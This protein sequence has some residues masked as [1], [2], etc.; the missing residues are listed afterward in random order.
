MTSSPMQKT[1]PSGSLP[2]RLTEPSSGPSPLSLLAVD[3]DKLRLAAKKEEENLHQFALSCLNPFL[4]SPMSFSE[5]KAFERQHDCQHFGY[6]SG[7][8]WYLPNS[9]VPEQIKRVADALNPEPAD[10]EFIRMALY[11]LWLTT[12]HER[13]PAQDRDAMLTIYVQNLSAYPVNAVRSVLMSFANN[14]VFFPAWAEVN[15]ALTDILGWRGQL[16]THLR[17]Y[18]MKRKAKA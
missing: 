3:Q 6:V 7:E 11:Q 16:L 10:S 5:M 13:M 2:A 8:I 17:N 15:Q 1:D 18:A 12:R 4:A 9:T 14:A